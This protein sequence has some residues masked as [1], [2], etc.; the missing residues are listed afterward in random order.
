MNFLK[1]LKGKAREQQQAHFSSPSSAPPEWSVAPE[2][3]HTFGLRNEAPEEEYEAAERF[4]EDNPPFPPRLMPASAVERINAVGCRAWGI[5]DPASPRFVGRIQ[6][7]GG[8]EKSGRAPV[9]YVTTGEGCKD[10]CLLS[11]LPIMAGLYDTQGKEGVYYEI[12]IRRM[13]GFLAIGECPLL[14]VVPELDR[15]N[16]N[17][18]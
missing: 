1:S 7:L 9:V 3:S 8:E 14:N 2:V 11:D 10:V 18:V 17:G 5:E 13:D 6:N 4:C 16:R 12:K 15:R